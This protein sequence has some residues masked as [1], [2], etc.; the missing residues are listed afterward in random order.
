MS[1]YL[2]RLGVPAALQALALAI[3]MLGLSAGAKGV[4][5]IPVA[6]SQWQRYDLSGSDFQAVDGIS[7]DTVWAAG[8]DGLLAH[9]NG[10]GWDPYDNTKIGP[11]N[12]NGI[13]VVAPDA[14]WAVADRAV[15]RWNGTAWVGEPVSIGN[16]IMQD[17]SMASLTDGWIVGATGSG[18]PVLA[19][20]NGTSWQQFSAP[21]ITRPMV[22]VDVVDSNNAWAVGGRFGPP[23]YG[24]MAR[25]DGASWA[26]QPFTATVF[27]AIDMLDATYGWAVGFSGA[28]WQWDG[29]TWTQF[30]PPSTSVNV[31]DVVVLSRTNAWAIAT[32]TPTTPT[33]WRWDGTSWSAVGAPAGAPVVGLGMLSAG[34]GWAVGARST[35]Y[36]WD[37]SA[38]SLSHSRANTSS[39]WAVDFL[40]PN[41]GWA[42][43]GEDSSL[44]SYE[45]QHWNGSTWEG[46]RF[47]PPRLSSLTWIWWRA[48][49]C[50][51]PMLMAASSAGMA[52]AGPWSITPLP[53]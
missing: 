2:V 31:Q 15:V 25:W 37:G 17:I 40:T 22:G 11:L 10:S 13:D 45:L 9:W 35:I 20:Y 6:G 1:R 51:P 26:A 33:I 18:S 46:Y 8:S 28:L 32:G 36:R 3:G 48:T 7:S 39:Y 52:Q 29:T 47:P 34:E 44:P 43:G 42:A 53:A 30:S 14:A 50:G 41:D 38:W 24:Q 16:A 21:A 4:E 23:P 49:R 5:P 12:F 19:R 27:T